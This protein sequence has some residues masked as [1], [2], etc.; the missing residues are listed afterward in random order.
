M[1]RTANGRS[2]RYGDNT[3]ARASP[4]IVFEREYRSARIVPDAASLLVQK[5]SAC[6]RNPSDFDASPDNRDVDSAR[7]EVNR[8]T[9]RVD[10]AWCKVEPAWFEVTPS[11]AEIESDG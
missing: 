9:Y 2:R 8:G 6:Q 10:P 7:F 11:P 4:I 3:K 5:S 1:V